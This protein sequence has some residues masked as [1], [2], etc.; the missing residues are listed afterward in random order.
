MRYCLA[1]QA[2]SLIRSNY[3]IVATGFSAACGQKQWPPVRAI[4]RDTCSENAKAALY[5][6]AIACV[7]AIMPCHAAQLHSPL[8]SESLLGEAIVRLFVIVGGAGLFNIS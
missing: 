1:T 5:S 2:T 4:C 6:L 3:A 8:T 7:C